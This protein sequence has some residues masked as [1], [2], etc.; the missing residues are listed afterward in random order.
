MLVSPPEF[1]C[2]ETVMRLWDYLDHELDEASTRAV[3]AHLE[4][5]ERC[6]PH[7]IFERRLLDA[8]R[9][10][11]ASGGASTTLRTRVAALLGVDP[12]TPWTAATGDTEG[13][14]D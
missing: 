1:D 3:D 2:R 4:R 8:I 5:C 14:H 11:R 7:F 10:V 6:P 12:T 13:H 9:A